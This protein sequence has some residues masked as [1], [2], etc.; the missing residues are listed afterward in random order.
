[1]ADL[2]RQLRFATLMSVR[3][4]VPNLRRLAAGA[5]AAAVGLVACWYGFRP[6]PGE[7]RLRAYVRAR[8]PVPVVFTSRSEPLSFETAAPDGEEFRYPGKRLWAASEGRLRALTPRGTV[9]ELTWGKPLPDGGTLADV[10]SPSV[11]LD[12]TKVLFAGRKGGD[13]AGHFRLYEVGVDGTG[14]RALTGGPGDTGADASPPMRFA[15][16][17]R[18]LPE[19]ERRR[20]DYDDVDPIEL[21]AD[22]RQIV[23]ASSRAPDLGRDHARRSTALWL[24]HPDG[25]KTQL[26]ANRNNDRW[27][28]AMSS[29]YVA[30]SLWSRNREVISADGTD[31]RPFDPAVPSLTQPTD[32]WLGALLRISSSGQFGVLVKPAAPVW[33]PRAL[34][35]GRI[36]FMTALDGRPGLTVVQAEPGLIGA[37]PSAAAGPLPRQSGAR[38][39]RGPERDADGR[40][41]WLGT[42]SP[43]PTGSVLLSGAPLEPGA[44]RPAPGAFGLYLASDDWPDQDE[45]VSAPAANL[46]LLFDDPDFVDAEPVAVY[47]RK[48][49]PVPLVS[50]AARVEAALTLANGKPYRGPAG[51]VLST[52]LDRAMMND[53]PGQQTDAG[54]APIFGPPPAGALQKLKV[55]AARRDRFDDPVRPRVPGAWELL[56]ELPVRDSAGGPVP[57]DS[58]TV[59]AGFGADGRV[60]RWETAAAD[61][62]GRRAAFYAIAGD[63]YSLTAPGGKHFC[64][65]CHPGHSGL[66]RSNHNHAEAFG[67]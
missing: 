49:Y 18:L 54:Q 62:T 60:A 21:R 53:L 52:G 48:V 1:R 43:C 15:P 29:G 56:V 30:F 57:T 50:E 13:D 47:P 55:F 51:M 39:R 44:T 42:P 38:L 2:D 24:M 4:R 37:A 6:D 11:T 20:T 27:P 7:P 59:L 58:P 45:P 34:W 17:G 64:V 66:P 5:V 36:A 41:L 28:W 67:N 35:N 12:G 63:H 23:F 65:G 10:I 19:P 46:S 25:H 31:V 22:P 61:S 26:T 14:L 33:R 3:L 8:P 40:A 16:D 9:H 32:A